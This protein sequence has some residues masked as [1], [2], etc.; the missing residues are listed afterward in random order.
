MSGGIRWLDMP[1]DAKEGWKRVQ[2]VVP[3][4]MTKKVT[5]GP[6]MSEEDPAEI[7]TCAYSGFPTSFPLIHPGSPRA[8][9]DLDHNGIHDQLNPQQQETE[10][11]YLR[12]MS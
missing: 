6:G 7:V 1:A 9:R 12:T 4:H 10:L 2:E 11:C 3:V 5:T 8:H